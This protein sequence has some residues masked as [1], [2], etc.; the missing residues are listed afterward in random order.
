M[1]I[2]K[3]YF[4]SCNIYP[5]HGVTFIR[6]D[7]K[8]F[9][10][11]RSKCHRA[12]KKKWNPRKTRWAK[13]FRKSVGKEL[14]VDPIFQFEQKRNIPIKYNRVIWKQT[15]KA[16]E[17]VEEISNKRKELYLLKRF[18]EKRDKITENNEHQ[19]VINKTL[20]ERSN[21]VDKKHVIDAV[22]QYQLKKLKAK[23]EPL[24]MMMDLD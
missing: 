19:V 20:I 18:D 21:D 15:V 14:A 12:Y 10:F 1:R 2:E 3:C 7:S 5:G 13:A 11:C 6:N 17:K 24:L 23:N 16:I 9:N 22:H 4:C 8:V